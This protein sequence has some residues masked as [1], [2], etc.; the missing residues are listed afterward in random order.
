M[1]KAK[2]LIV[3]D[4]RIIAEDIKV[5]L[6]HMGY[7]VTAIATSGEEALEAVNIQ[8]PDIALMDIRLGEGMNGIET[9]MQLKQKHQ[10]S[11]IYLTAHAD[12]DTVSRAKITE[13]YGYLVKPFGDS[14]LQSAIEIALY[15]Q[16]ADRKVKESQ[17][18]LQTTLTSIGDGVIATDKSGCVVFMNPVAEALTGWTQ[19]E[20]IGLSL[21]EV[22]TIVNEKS[23][24]PV[25][26]P[27][28][29]VLQKGVVVG[30]ANHTLL[31]SSDGTEYPIADSAAPIRNDKG[32]LRGVVLV[33]RD[34]TKERAA[35][36]AIERRQQLLAAISR[37]QARFI[38][39]NDPA[40]VFDGILSD[41]LALADSEYGFIGEVIYSPE[42]QPYLKCHALTNIAWNKETQKNYDQNAPNGLEFRNLETLFGASLITGEPVIAKDPLNDPLRGGLPEGHPPVKSFLGI[43]IHLGGK[44]LAMAGMA[45]RP[46]GYDQELI[47]FLKP[48]LVSIAQLVEAFR[49]RAEHDRAKEKIKE[50]ETRYRTI[51]DN[52]NEGIILQDA[53]GSIVT[54]NKAAERVFGIN[55]EDVLRHTPI[56]REWH[57]IREDGSPFPGSAHPSMVSLSTGVPCKDVVMGVKN[58]SGGVTWISINANPLFAENV[59]RPCGVVITFSDITELK[60][61][62]KDR[63]KLQEQLVQAQKMESVGRLAGGVAHDFNNMLGIIIGHAE[64][65]MDQVKPDQPL[66]AGLAEI[67]KAAD[68]SADLTRQL[69][70]FARKQTVAPRVLDLNETVEGMLRMLRRL[71]GEQINL[72]WLPGNGLWPVNVDPSQI[73]QILANLCVNARDAISDVG[74]VTIETENVTIDDA[75]CADHAEC[76]PGDYV[77]LAVSDNGCGMDKEILASI[78]E[79]FF[80]TKGVGQ[81]TG[82]GLST[83]YGAVRQNNGFVNAYSEPGQGT[84][85]KIYLPRHVGKAAQLEKEGIA[86]PAKGGNETILLV[87]DEPAILDMIQIMLE[88]QGY[89]VLPAG[90]PGKAIRLAGEHA[91]QIHLLM[92]DVV[93]PEMNGRD[94]ARKLLSLYPDLKRLFMSGYTADVIAHHG[95]LDPGVN[96]IQKP[97]T[98]KNLAASVRETI[99]DVHK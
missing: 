48:F 23:R 10:V 78:F 44:M 50:S 92:T 3:E 32:E 45:N 37:G 85:F 4:N 28:A 53:S 61:S 11:V 14:E 70:A 90:T 41:L 17:K 13:P 59:S 5:K 56:G 31:I 76:F 98:M 18:W 62:E 24:Q 36:R 8:I 81:G 96:F 99:G 72:S 57:T 79:P 97:F 22:F 93:M 1:E 47:D 74:K 27:V 66:F 75:Y 15:K 25:E 9:A 51:I 95:V 12:G 35:W 83:V 7:A 43:P 73:D 6:G 80:T 67:R 71:I 82:L 46:G 20:A 39:D 65:A 58:T 55:E 88:M 26:N 42:G 69:L 91:G 33:F 89:T 49:H 77:R 40:G 52:T 60:R 30:L 2:I 34:Q 19:P 86:D 29:K 54:W 94:L 38:A 87:E 16:Q 84:T 68:R 63:E 64:M 21:H